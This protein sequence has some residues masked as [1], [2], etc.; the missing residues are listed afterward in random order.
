MLWLFF[1]GFC[2]LFFVLI[3]VGVGFFYFNAA[4]NLNRVAAKAPL[5]CRLRRPSIGRPTLPPGRSLTAFLRIPLN[6]A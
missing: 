6:E 2:C 5:S 1:C 3:V 4:N